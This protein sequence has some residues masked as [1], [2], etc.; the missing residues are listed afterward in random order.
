MVYNCLLI[1]LNAC[2]TV[3]VWVCESCS[4]VVVF[5][6]W[7]AASADAQISNNGVAHS[8]H[9]TTVCLFCPSTPSCLCMCVSAPQSPGMPFAPPTL[10]TQAEAGNPGLLAKLGRVLKEKAAGD[11]ERFFKGTSKTRERLGVRRGREGKGGSGGGDR[12]AFR[13]SLTH[14]CLRH[15]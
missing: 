5:C 11:Y 15:V 2:L 9:C 10:Q 7:S 3:L 1:Q 13:S 6:F 8:L 4:G 14:H 12:C